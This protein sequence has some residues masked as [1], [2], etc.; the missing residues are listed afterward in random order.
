MWQSCN[1]LTLWNQE[2]Q[3][4]IINKRERKAK[5]DEFGERERVGNF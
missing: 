3:R 5:V 4:V 2:I 1:P